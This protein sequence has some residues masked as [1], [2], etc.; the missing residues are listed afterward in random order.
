MVNSVYDENDDG[1]IF[2]F[3]QV[4]VVWLDECVRSH[5]LCILLQNFTACW[6]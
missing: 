5:S 2:I 4:Y 3:A 6:V 1:F